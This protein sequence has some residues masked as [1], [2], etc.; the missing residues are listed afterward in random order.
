MAAVTATGTGGGTIDVNTIV[1]QLMTI[2]QRPLTLLDN[3]EAGF[4]GQLS[5]Y[6]TLR[7]ALST[8][9]SSA[10]ALGT[11]AKFQAF[12]A[13]SS[14]ST[15]LSGTASKTAS[16]GSYNIDVS[17]LAQAQSIVSAG[18]SSATAAIGTGL[19]TTLTIQFGAITGGSLTNGAYTG[20]TFTQDGT[21]ASG[22]VTIDSSNN[23]LQG[24]RDAINKANLGVTA[25]IVKDGSA[26]PYRL[27]L[28]SESSGASHAIRI[29]VSGDSTLQSLLGYDAGGTQNLTQTGTAKDA[30]LTVNGV[31]V[32][33]ATNSFSDT[34]EG[35]S[36][37]AIKV[38]AA[39]LSVGRDTAGATS[40]VAS[41]VKS[42]N[43]LNATLA[44][45]TKF[46]ATTK[47]G[48]VLIGEATVRTVQSQVRSVLTASLSGLSTGGYQTLSQIG[49]SFQRDGSLSIDSTKLTAALTTNG[50]DVAALFSA[51]GGPTDSLVHFSS[52]TAATK[53]GA[54]AVNITQLATQGKL[55]GFAPAGLTITAG[56]NDQLSVSVDGISST[57]QLSAGTY[58]A[59]TLAAHLQAAIN[60]TSAFSAAGTS[61]SVAQSLGTLTVTSKTYGAA[62]LVS[63]AGNGADNLFGTTPTLSNGLDVAGTINGSVATGAG[64][65][66]TGQKGSAIEGLSLDINGGIVGDRGTVNFSR[67][68]ADQV[69]T[70]IT[71]LLG[72]TGALQ[73]RTDGLNRSIGDIGK[74]RT[75]VSTRLDAIEK[76]YRAQFTALDQLVSSMQST[77]AFLTQQL[78]ALPGSG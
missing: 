21:A 59:A 37:T 44:N 7:G 63:V 23:S 14:D 2:E 43:D 67:G 22:T 64:Q 71:G 60:G 5:A 18:Q 66:L 31:S 24:V 35:V 26:S 47:T 48:G 36:L 4:Q 9:Q 68:Y 17:V 65:T 70:L 29:G 33:S 61:V 8:F 77:S 57:V 12:S 16:A 42:Y 45:L 39:T 40:A 69:N 27:V 38:G 32:T 51:V 73:G 34:I 28:T 10:S 1:S 55:A 15:I 52:S 72:T 56:V 11:L 54:Y 30:Q 41:F 50:D 76:R 58:T 46:D 20:A 13:S 62:S 25:S 78:A 19:Q 49:L 6:G 53:A 3:K 74:Q 75:A